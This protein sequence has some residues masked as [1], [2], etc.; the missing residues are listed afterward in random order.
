MKTITFI[1]VAAAIM[2]AVCGA[3]IRPPAYA[4]IETLSG[5]AYYSGQIY[6]ASH[7][8]TLLLNK[9]GFRDLEFQGRSVGTVL[10]HAL[11][12]VTLP[13]DSLPSP[14]RNLEFDVVPPDTTSPDDLPIPSPSQDG[15]Y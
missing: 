4:K 15:N 14:L 3:A 13:L 11:W 1:I 12:P 2:A 7:Q 8:D 5:K 6:L 10:Y 9:Y